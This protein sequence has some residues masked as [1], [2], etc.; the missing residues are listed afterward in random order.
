MI[1]ELSGEDRRNVNI[2]ETTVVKKTTPNICNNKLIET[3]ECY[4]HLGENYNLVKRKVARQG[5]PNTIL[6]GGVTYA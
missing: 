5:Y 3:V 2:S 4:M 1:Q 6:T